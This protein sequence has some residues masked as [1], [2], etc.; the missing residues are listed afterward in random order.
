[1]KTAARILS[2]MTML[3]GL[4]VATVSSASPEGLNPRTERKL[5]RQAVS[6]KALSD[7]C[8][9]IKNITG[10][11]FLWKSEISPHIPRGDA[12]ASGPTLICNRDCPTKFPMEFFYSDGT[13]AGAVG[14]YGRWSYTNKPRAYCAAGGAPRCYNS[15]IRSNATKNGRDGKIYLQFR[16]KGTSNTL[17]YRANPVGRNGDAHP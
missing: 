3:V 2:V 13:K 9:T 1:M 7:V 11:E 16:G 15:V 6:T 14:Y 12:R 10:K 5:A 17:C 4:T 8:K